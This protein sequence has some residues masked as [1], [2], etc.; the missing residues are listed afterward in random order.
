MI[1][2]KF[3]LT[4]TGQTGIQL[5]VAPVPS[6]S[7]RW[8]ISMQVSEAM[9]HLKAGLDKLEKLGFDRAVMD[10]RA[11]A[12]SADFGVKL[13]PAFKGY[14]FTGP[15]AAVEKF[16]AWIAKGVRASKEKPDA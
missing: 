6:L 12:V 1:D 4:M 14:E 5:E 15:P 3:N 2:Q 11:K 13:R 9:A 16:K 10:E 8:E 7:V